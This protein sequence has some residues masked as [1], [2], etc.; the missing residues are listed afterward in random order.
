MLADLLQAIEREAD[1]QVAALRAEAEADVAR[2]EQEAA[3]ARADRRDAA[4]RHVI[5]ELQARADLEVATAER[6]ARTRVL[7]ARA[8]MID[9]L[10][11][12][13]RDRLPDL[14]DDT[15]GRALVTAALAGA[16]AA[17]ATLRCAPILVELA[18]SHA[19][20]SVRVEPADELVG[21][22]LDRP[23]MRIDATLDTLLDREWPALAALALS[24]GAR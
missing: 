23:G 9:R 8:A 16:T 2:I 20:P 5:D 22:I 4:S 19:P 24:G 12:R 3:R 7:A 15:T 11:T 17:A 18:R 10:R 13:V 1:G 14:L 21:A 6:T